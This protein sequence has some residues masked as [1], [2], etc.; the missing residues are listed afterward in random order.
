VTFTTREEARQTKTVDVNLHI[1]QRCGFVFNSLFD[2]S[3][4]HYSPDYHTNQGISPR[5]EEHLD[6][7]IQF[8]I[9]K[10]YKE[11]RVVEIGCGK[12][13][14]LQ[15]L[16]V[17]GFRQIKGF[18]PGYEGD[19]PF[20]TK[21]YFNPQSMTEVADLIIFR[22][23]FDQIAQPFQLLE[24]IA[25][26]NKNQG[27]VFIEVPAFEWVVNEGAIWDIENERCNYFTKD[28]L[29]RFFEE[30]ESYYSFGDQ[31][32]SFTAPLSR[33]RRE[34]KFLE[35]SATTAS[36]DVFQK[37]LSHWKRFMSETEGFLVVWG[38]SGK[39]VAFANLL[40]SECQKIN[41]L[42]DIDLKKQGR[43]IGGTGHKIISP[44][45]LKEFRDS[46]MTIIVANKNY[47]DEIKNEVE[48]L[49]TQILT[50]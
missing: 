18:D 13:H 16:S 15:K 3:I 43:F 27:N 47:L 8:L 46:P 31:Y 41:Y 25:L 4:M 11:K 29:E 23:V 14:F 49:D 33:L 21:D 38:S 17:A 6:E 5:F 9:S 34:I 7:T 19:A 22:F 10:G 26:L 37:C 1:C 28:V 20:I 40:D 30:S 44:A 48:V 35:S 36:F 2:E 42:I 24:Q 12:G 50:L 39:G 45:E 32:L